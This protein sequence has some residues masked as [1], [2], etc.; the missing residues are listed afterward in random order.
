[1]LQN[2][3]F[4]RRLGLPPIGSI[5]YPFSIGVDSPI[6]HS[7]ASNPTRYSRARTFTALLNGTA[8]IRR[9]G[10]IT[11]TDLNK[12]LNDAM[13]NEPNDAMNVEGGNEFSTLEVHTLL[14]RLEGRDKIM[15][16][17]DSGTIYTIWGC[18]L[19]QVSLVCF[20]L[21]IHLY[22][23]VYT[24]PLFFKLFNDRCHLFVW[25]WV[26]AGSTHVTMISNRKKMSLCYVPVFQIVAL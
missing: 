11:I 23:R 4:S 1:M 17:W 20:P 12:E 13:R 22:T 14:K 16:D 18:I 6:C 21:V 2:I 19:L 3:S 25:I 24:M 26:A 5:V 7:F 9:D 15:V 8:K 10:C